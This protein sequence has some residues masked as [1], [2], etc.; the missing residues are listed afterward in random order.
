MIFSKILGLPIAAALFSVASAA[1]AAEADGTL[2][3]RATT[4]SNMLLI[5]LENTDF[6][7]AFADPNLKAFASTGVLFNNWLAFSHPSQ[8]NYIAMTSG[9]GNGITSDSSKTIN[10]QSIADL[11]E[12][13]GLTWKSY[14]E[15]WPGNCFTGTSSGSY[16]RSV[17]HHRLSN[18][19]RLTMHTPGSTIRLSATPIF[20]RTRRVAPRSLMHPSLL[21]ISRKAQRRHLLGT[22]YA[23]LLNSK[24]LIELRSI[25]H[26]PTLIMTATILV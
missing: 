11:L 4:F 9:S 13:K 23:Q 21:P 10:V 1:P 8:P 7:T 20:R 25:R 6:S 17:F 26:S 14:Q 19:S 18:M 15:N 2:S 12:A 22:R 24:P 16:F 5:I 3:G